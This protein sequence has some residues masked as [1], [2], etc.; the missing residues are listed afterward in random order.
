MKLLG[1][2]ISG[3]LDGDINVD[4]QEMFP[5]D[6]LP[7]K[8]LLARQ[9]FILVLSPHHL[10]IVP[11]NEDVLRIAKNN[12]ERVRTLF[13]PPPPNENGEF[14]PTA[15]LPPAGEYAQTMPDATWRRL[16]E[17]IYQDVV[18]PEQ[19]L[20]RS[21][22]Q[23]DIAK[24]QL[25]AN[26]LRQYYIPQL[27]KPQL[28]PLPLETPSILSISTTSNHA[29]YFYAGLPNEMIKNVVNAYFKKKEAR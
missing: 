20:L 2:S 8:P 28:N 23:V 22:T 7:Q 14:P 13:L 10:L 17:T 5:G 24:G 9:N 12:W 11:G 29:A 3:L 19:H 1:G 15:P 27:P 21:A 18:H 25:M 6:S 26:Y 16:W 4:F